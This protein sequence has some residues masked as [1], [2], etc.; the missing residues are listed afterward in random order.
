MPRMDINKPITWIGNVT[1]R[2]STGSYS[3]YIRRHNGKEIRRVEKNSG[4]ALEHLCLNFIIHQGMP[5][6]R[7]GGGE[8]FRRICLLKV[9]KEAV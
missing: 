7:C 9:G 4:N 6:V 8:P 3:L 2:C 5:S 1:E